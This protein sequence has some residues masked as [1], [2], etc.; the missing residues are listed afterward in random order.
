[1]RKPGHHAVALAP[2]RRDVFWCTWR[3]FR[4]AAIIVVVYTITGPASGDHDIPVNSFSKG[5]TQILSVKRFHREQNPIS[6]IRCAGFLSVRDGFLKDTVQRAVIIIVYR[7]TPDI[8]FHPAVQAARTTVVIKFTG[9][10]V[11][12]QVPVASEL[13]IIKIGRSILILTVLCCAIP[14]PAFLHRHAALFRMRVAYEQY[15]VDSQRSVVVHEPLTQFIRRRATGAAAPA[16]P[17][18]FL[19]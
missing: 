8:D 13:G 6:P 2:F 10:T 5:I 16:F 15:I 7:Y 17:K 9:T 12:V 18:A 19:V 1:M 14:R 4:L 3:F 11:I